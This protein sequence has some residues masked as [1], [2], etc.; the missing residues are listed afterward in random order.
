MNLPIEIIEIIIQKL[1]SNERF[2]AAVI[3]HLIS[4]RNKQVI[5]W[6]WHENMVM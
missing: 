6:I 3:L 2:I 5:Q 1:N 4:I